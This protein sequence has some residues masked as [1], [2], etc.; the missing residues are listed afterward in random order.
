MAMSRNTTI[1]VKVGVV[2]DMDTWLGKMGLS[3][4]SMALS[5]F[6]ASHGHYKTRL[7][8]EIRDSKRDVVGAA[9]ADLLRNEE[10]QAIIGLASS[11]QANFVIDLGH[12]AHVPIISFSATSPSLSSLQS[13]YFVRAILKYDSVQVPTIRAIVQAFG[14][15]Q[16]VLIYLDNEYGN[17]VIPYLTDAL[18][19]IDTRLQERHS[20]ISH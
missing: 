6:Y 18:Q 7:V 20:S 9:A 13:Q 11:M 2:L 4:I 12:K 19:E 3:C 8:L 10:V 17:G 5:D 16:V 1:P 15:R 14:W